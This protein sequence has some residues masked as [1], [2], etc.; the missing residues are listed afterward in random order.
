MKSSA[1]LEEEWLQRECD[2]ANRD[3]SPEPFPR[4]RKLF[5]R[6]REQKFL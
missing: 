4:I 3:P 5:A 6:A 2:R 1:A